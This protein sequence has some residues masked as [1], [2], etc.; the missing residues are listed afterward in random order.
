MVIKDVHNGLSVEGIALPA[1]APKRNRCHEF[2]DIRA[3]QRTLSPPRVLRHEGRLAYLEN[4]GPSASIACSASMW[5]FVTWFL[6]TTT[7]K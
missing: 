4:S 7:V 1:D 2:R 5:L 6:T 3:G